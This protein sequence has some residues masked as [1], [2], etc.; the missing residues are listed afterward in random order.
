MNNRNPS[1]RGCLPNHWEHVIGNQSNHIAPSPSRGCNQRIFNPFK[2]YLPHPR[3]NFQS[4]FD[5]STGYLPNHWEALDPRGIP[6]TGN[7]PHLRDIIRPTFDPLAGC[8]PNHW[9]IFDSRH[10]PLMFDPY[11]GC[12]PNHWA[13]FNSISNPI[14][15][16]FP[17]L[18]EHFH[19][20]F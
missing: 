8:L 1:R 15:G 19:L 3:G 11:T 7:L 6:I 9:D 2:R 13:I 4:L 16:Y 17:H 14:T 20:L 18:R 10:N 5:P 12:L